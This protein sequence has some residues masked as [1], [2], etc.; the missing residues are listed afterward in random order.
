[1]FLCVLWTVLANSHKEDR[2]KYPPLTISPITLWLSGVPRRRLENLGWGRGSPCVRRI[3]KRENLL[4]QLL[5]PSG[6]RGLMAPPADSVLSVIQS[7]YWVTTATEKGHVAWVT[8]AQTDIAGTPRWLPL[9]I[10]GPQWADLDLKNPCG[11]CFKSWDTGD[12]PTETHTRPGT[13]WVQLPPGG[14]DHQKRWPSAPLS[15]QQGEGCQSQ[16]LQTCGT[17]EEK[18]KHPIDTLGPWSEPNLKA[19]PPQVLV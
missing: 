10:L 3:G 1:M 14:C 5:S 13:F 7:V 8:S 6:S 19:I 17:N 12:V 15:L 18:R 2:G 4:S 16:S 11:T 9:P